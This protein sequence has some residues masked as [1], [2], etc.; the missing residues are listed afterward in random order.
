MS[1]EITDNEEVDFS[2]VKY[3]LELL[4]PEVRARAIELAKCNQLILR[5]NGRSPKS[6]IDLF[7]WETTSEG[8]DYWLD[9]DLAIDTPSLRAGNKAFVKSA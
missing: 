3:D 5:V 4:I 1:K 8:V 2:R 7:T 6:F 9:I